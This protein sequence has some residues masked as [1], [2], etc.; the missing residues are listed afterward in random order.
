MKVGFTGT[1]KGMTS[2]QKDTFAK[3]LKEVSAHVFTHGDC[4]GADAQAHEIA[5]KNR[6]LYIEKRPCTLPDQ[7]AWT[8][9]GHKCYP[10]E[11]PALRNMRIVDDCEVL[12]ATPGGFKEVR[13][14]GT[15]MTIR[16]ARKVGNL[17]III[18]PDGKREEHIPKAN[19]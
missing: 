16:Y 13:R 17:V 14:S 19:F 8:I 1:R 11:A 4:I 10:P 7:R 3:V 9:G 2:E 15:W 5:I 18:W 6:W 12:I